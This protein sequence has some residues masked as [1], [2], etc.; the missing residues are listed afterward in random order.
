MVDALRSRGTIGRESTERAL[1]AV[2]RHAFV[3]GSREGEAYADRP[4]PIGDG[5]TISA[6]HMV[7]KM[8]DLLDL[9][10][11][12]RVLEVGTGCGYHA[13]IAAE[14]VGPENLFSV[15]Y[16][17]DLAESA[18]EA[19]SEIGY[20][21]VSIRVGDGREGW[22]EH[23]PYDAIYLTCAA[24]TLPDALVEQLRGEGPIVAPI[25]TRSQTLYRFW[26]REDGSLDRE[27][28]GGVR[29]V[30]MR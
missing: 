16:G 17:A 14:I 7:G 21:G 30:R 3:P 4:L 24:P 29:F 18:R 12:E 22:P 10:G 6:P 5:Q 26:R 27:N 9:E 1:R 20:E 2:P 13:A 28:H 25:G 15:E 19:L 8:V 23:A 11:S